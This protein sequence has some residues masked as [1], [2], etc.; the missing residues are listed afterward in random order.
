MTISAITLPKGH[1]PL[2][3]SRRDAHRTQCRG[4]EYKYKQT[5]VT[6]EV[7]IPFF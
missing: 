5:A 4:T 3:A 1:G 6:N 2:V 7:L